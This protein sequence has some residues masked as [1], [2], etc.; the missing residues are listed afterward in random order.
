MQLCYTWGMARR[1]TLPPLRTKGFAWGNERVR[2]GLS[3]GELSRRVGI[4]KGTLSYIESGR[5]VP[6]GEEFE[7]VMAVL[8]DAERGSAE[9]APSTG[10]DPG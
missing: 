2:A 8:R 6:T 5:M 3:L 7:R 4:N 10:G 1:H 9:P